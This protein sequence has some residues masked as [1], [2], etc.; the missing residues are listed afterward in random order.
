MLPIFPRKWIFRLSDIFLNLPISICKK[1]T[2]ITLDY[3]LLSRIIA[4]KICA[5]KTDV[6]Q[7]AINHQNFHKM[8]ETKML[9][10]FMR[11]SS[12][13]VKLQVFTNSSLKNQLVLRY[14]WSIYFRV[15]VSYL[16][17]FC[18]KLL[19][20]SFRCFMYLLFV[21]FWILQIEREEFDRLITSVRSCYRE[22]KFYGVWLEKRQREKLKETKKDLHFL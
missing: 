7:Y 13:I 11:K 6:C 15:N 19:S 22:T 9:E 10:K 3:R 4:Q 14:F 8:F 5:I 17:L 1:F 16:N 2:R 12:A 18:R 21:S 20:G